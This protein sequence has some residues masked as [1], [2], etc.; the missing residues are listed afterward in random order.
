MESFILLFQA[1]IEIVDIN[2]TLFLSP[3]VIAKR[4]FL[5]SYSPQVLMEL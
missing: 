3:A 4:Q 2:N 1:T 5:W